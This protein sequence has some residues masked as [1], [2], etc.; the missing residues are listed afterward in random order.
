MCDGR[1]GP[2]FFNKKIMDFGLFDLEKALEEVRTVIKGIKEVELLRISQEFISGGYEK[3]FNVSPGV[4]LAAEF[5]EDTM[6]RELP[7]VSMEMERYQRTRSHY[8]SIASKAL[9][10]KRIY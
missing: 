10:T 7:K 3:R 9:L 6:I 5:G 2:F 8:K 1:C 4:V